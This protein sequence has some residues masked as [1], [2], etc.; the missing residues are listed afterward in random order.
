MVVNALVKQQ[1]NSLL[2]EWSRNLKSRFSG[3]TPE[4]TFLDSLP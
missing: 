2:L 4:K 3:V 1:L